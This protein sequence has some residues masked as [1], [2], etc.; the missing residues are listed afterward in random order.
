MP[1]V[2][3]RL[4]FGVSVLVAGPSVAIASGI[5]GCARG[6]TVSASSSDADSF[7]E[8][9]LCHVHAVAR[10]VI[11]SPAE[12]NRFLV[13]SRTDVDQAYVQCMSNRS[14]TRLLC[15]A[16]SGFYRY[17]EGDPRRFRHWRSQV[18]ALAALGFDTSVAQGNFTLEVWTRDADEV[19]EAAR[20]MLRA[21][22]EGFEATTLD[23]VF[24]DAPNVLSD[25]QLLI[26][27]P[28]PVS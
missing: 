19:R 21:M 27:C 15:E 28:P 18:E 14:G 25:E 17:A 13:L 20:L 16:A 12:R 10:D 9:F 11:S 8:T 5:S 2:V 7:V 23:P 6:A 24:I 4:L 1:M 3:L 22:A 26:P